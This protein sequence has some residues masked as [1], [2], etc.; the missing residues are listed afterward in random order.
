MIGTKQNN[1]DITESGQQGITK[2]FN[3]K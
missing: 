1:M 3:S 2:A